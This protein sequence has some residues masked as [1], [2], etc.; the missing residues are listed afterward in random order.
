MLIML[1]MLI[2]HAFFE[3]ESHRDPSVTINILFSKPF[4][5]GK[6]FYFDLAADILLILH[7]LFLVTLDLFEA[8]LELEL[9]VVKYQFN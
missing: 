7:S 9:W 4:Q 3:W 8:E 5:A 1:I 2:M 6:T